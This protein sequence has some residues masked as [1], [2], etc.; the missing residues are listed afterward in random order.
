MTPEEIQE[1]KD[2]IKLYK[3]ADLFSGIMI[4]IFLL[5]AILLVIWEIY[6]L[7][8]I[9]K[10]HQEWKMTLTEEQIKTINKNKEYL[11]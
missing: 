9:K 11:K 10:M 2:L 3:E 1:L 4:G 5:G 7:K 6:R 8:A